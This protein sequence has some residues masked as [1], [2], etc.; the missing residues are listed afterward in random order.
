M[1]VHRLLINVTSWM[2]LIV[3]H[4]NY[5]A[6]VANVKA[7]YYDAH[8]KTCIHL[9]DVQTPTKSQNSADICTIRSLDE[10][11]RLLPH[12][13]QSDCS[14]KC[15]NWTK[16]HLC[17]VASSFCP[18]REWSQERPRRWCL[19]FISSVIK[20][21]VLCGSITDSIVINGSRFHDLRTNLGIGSIREQGI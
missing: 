19:A 15:S 14:K 2:T 7:A 3:C 16:K 17:V 5:I 6:N 11:A 12:L 10:I 13:F 18:R 4:S 9:T 20:L 21:R 8:W 1:R